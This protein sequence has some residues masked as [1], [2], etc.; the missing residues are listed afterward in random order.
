MRSIR[1]GISMALVALAPLLA[2]EIKLP[3][4]LGAHA[5]D[6]VEV[7]LDSNMLQL[8]SKFLS[9]SNPDEVQAKKLVAGLKSILVR[10]FEYDKPGQYNPGELESVR[11]Q[12]RGTGWT[13]VI[14][15]DSKKDSETSEVYV[16]SQ[17]GTVAGVGLISAEPKEL[18]IVL[19]NGTID[20]DQISQLSGKFGI[21]KIDLGKKKKTGKED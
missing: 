7:T 6:T 4:S 3:P 16:K 1:Y 18:T 9:G 19:I 13:R 15:V 17:N 5:S 20:P 10:S 21:P 8:A 11:A 2:Q 12:F 14:G